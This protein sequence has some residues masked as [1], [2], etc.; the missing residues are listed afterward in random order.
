MTKN[1]GKPVFHE[2]AVGI[3]GWD[4]EVTRWITIKALNRDDAHSQACRKYRYDNSV[5]GFV[6]E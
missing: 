4:G 5:M 1:A 3:V 2:Y 6:F